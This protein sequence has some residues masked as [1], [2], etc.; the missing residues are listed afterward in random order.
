MQRFDENVRTVPDRFLDRAFNAWPQRAR[1]FVIAVAAEF[2][3]FRKNGRDVVRAA[4]LVAELS[5]QLAQL[6][7]IA[8]EKK[9]TK[10]LEFLHR[11]GSGQAHLQRLS[12]GHAELVLQ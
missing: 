5:A 7:A 12:S 10:F 3:R 2:D 8:T 9:P 11:V 4:F 1:E 6:L